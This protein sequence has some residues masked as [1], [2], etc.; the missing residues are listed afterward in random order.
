MSEDE[1][2]RKPRSF[3]ADDPDVN[4]SATATQQVDDS[5]GFADNTVE[6]ILREARP[7]DAGT[8]VEPRRS[9]ISWTGLF[10]SAAVGLFVLATGVWFSRFVSVALAR[11]DW[12]GWT[13]WGLAIVLLFAL[14]AMVVTEVIGFVRLSRLRGLRKQANKAIAADDQKLERQVVQ[15]LK[16]HVR[17]QRNQRW[18]FDRF[19]EQERHMRE[20]GALMGLAD[21]VLLAEPDKDAR[22]IIYQS[23]KRVGVVTAVVPI[24]FVVVLFVLFE[25]LRMV[26]RLAGAYGCRPGFLGGVRLFGWIIAHIAATG[27]IALT[28]DLWGQFFGQDMLRRLSRKLG[29]G[30]FNGAMTARLGVA[31]LDICRPLPFIT[32]KPPRA[33]HI[34]YQAFPQL[35]PGELAR[36]V[37]GGKRKD[38][39]E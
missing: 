39:V 32:A 12:L 22:A 7:D 37:V 26:R 21:S 17:T 5:E 10:L 1:R 33:R 14:G 4:V 16:R 31:A 3:A 11:E 8:T 18:D 2:L 19:R 28:D 23:S 25:N 38:R 27:V 9:F 24:A 36:K 30:A 13:A 6:D 34:F 29:E 20:P 35:D 15:R